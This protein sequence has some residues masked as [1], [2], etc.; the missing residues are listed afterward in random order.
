MRSKIVIVDYGSS[1]LR[2]VARAFEYVVQGRHTVEVSADPNQIAA[3]DRVVFPGQGAIGDCMQRLHALGLDS[4]LRDCMASRPFLGICLGL[5]SLLSHS[6]EDDG[7]ECLDFIAGQ[8]MRFPAGRI[9]TDSGRPYK[10]PHMG[11]NEVCWAKPHPLVEGIP[12]KTR[13]YFVH[14]YHVVPEDDS[15]V[16][17]RTDYVVPFVS[18]IATGNVFATQFHPEK[19]QQ[20]GLQLISNFVAWGGIG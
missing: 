17:A 9:D 15:V 20:A 8:V 5:Q 2:S 4:V 14:S 18:A 3:A 10:I 6:D 11:W 16:A 1:N 13:F 7:T 19:S 12:D